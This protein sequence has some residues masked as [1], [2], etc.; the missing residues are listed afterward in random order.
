MR[1]GAQWD[2]VYLMTVHQRSGEYL[3]PDDVGDATQ[4]LSSLREPGR[5]PAE[6]ALNPPPD[7]DE[8]AVR[9]YAEAGATWRI[10]LDHADAG[11]SRHR[12]HI[13]RGL[14]ARWR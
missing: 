4:A 5:P 9:E 6:V 14:P 11:P 13:R 7:A 12:E 8:A 1:R 10:E 3:R 2:G